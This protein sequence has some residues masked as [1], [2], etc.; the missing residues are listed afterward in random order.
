MKKLKLLI[1]AFGTLTALTA[2]VPAVSCGDKEKEEDPKEIKVELADGVQNITLSVKPEKPVEGE[3]VTITLTAD[4]DYTIDKDS[5]KVEIGTEKIT[6]KPKMSADNT[7]ATILISGEDVDDDI[8]VSAKAVQSEEGDIHSYLDKDGNF[9]PY[10]AKI[11]PLPKDKDKFND[12]SEVFMF[13]IKEVMTNNEIITDDYLYYFSQELE[14]MI[15]K[16]IKPAEGE[17]LT[18]EAGLVVN[19]I[20]FQDDMVKFSGRVYNK[21]V[22]NI[23]NVGELT[24]FSDVNFENVHVAMT[25]VSNETRGINCGY[26]QDVY[27]DPSK[28]ELDDWKVVGVAQDFG[29]EAQIKGEFNYKNWFNPEATTELAP[30]LQRLISDF[31]IRNQHYMSLIDYKNQ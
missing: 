15:E 24:S 5:I 18:A 29:S 12:E 9:V 20:V 28:L 27:S 31:K 4:K 1:P 11:D 2:V 10:D 8:T 7:T 30:D 21:I 14:E 25:A 26:G 6:C 13:Y 16:Q 19:K 17:L 22:A 3:S 23:P